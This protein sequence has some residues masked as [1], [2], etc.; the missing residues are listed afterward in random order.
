LI[1]IS[2]LVSDVSIPPDWLNETFYKIVKFEEKV[3]RKGF[4]G[5]S[6]FLRLEKY[7]RL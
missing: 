6:L 4:F 1:D 2:K 3:L 5:S 7:Q